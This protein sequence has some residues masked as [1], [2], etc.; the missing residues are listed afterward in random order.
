[1]PPFAVMLQEFD[2]DLLVAPV[3]YKEIRQVLFSLK[4][5][6][7]LGSDGL[8]AGFYHHC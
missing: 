7:A 8:H 3:E 5:F 6:I 1:M 2:V 4:S